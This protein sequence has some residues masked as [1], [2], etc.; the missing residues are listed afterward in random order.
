M[1]LGLGRAQ[2]G[3]PQ[4]RQLTGKRLLRGSQA[5]VL[6]LQALEQ[7]P[8]SGPSQ[9]VLQPPPAGRLPQQRQQQQ[10]GQGQG[11]RRR[12]GRTGRRRP[13]LPQSRAPLSRCACA[14]RPHPLRRCPRSSSRSAAPVLRPSG[15]RGLGYHPRARSSAVPAPCQSRGGPLQQQHRRHPP[16][17]PTLASWP[18]HPRGRQGLWLLDQPLLGPPC[19]A[20]LRQSR[21]SMRKPPRSVVC[22]PP[23]R[24]WLQRGQ[25]LHLHLQSQ[26]L[27]PQP[28]WPGQALPLVAGQH[29]RPQRALPP[30]PPRCRRRQA[31]PRPQRCP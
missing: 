22:R 20:Q 31:Q 24:L 11:S 18:A 15:R 13:A 8:P 14:A 9:A 12:P 21:R 3:P 2:V 19:L 29:A 26:G 4:R 17:R 7:R 25:P 16:S 1:W 23:L 28:Q 5:R 27:Q 10:Q 6:P 30:R